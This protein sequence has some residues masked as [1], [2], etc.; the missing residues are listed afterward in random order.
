[1]PAPTAL[2]QPTTAHEA[3]PVPAPEQDDEFLVDMQQSSTDELTAA[4][5]PTTTED[6]DMAIDE[7]G[8]PRFA[9]GAD[10]VRGGGSFSR[11][12]T[13]LLMAFLV[14][15]RTRSA[16]PRQERFPFHRIACPR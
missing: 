11:S 16:A 12:R 6:T 15:S 7:E 13:N 4:A 9:P 10:V 3:V 5:P 8:R 1:M 2:L 14:S